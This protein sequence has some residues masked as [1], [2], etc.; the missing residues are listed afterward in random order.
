[1]IEPISQPAVSGL[2]GAVTNYLNAKALGVFL[3]VGSIWIIILL[4]LVTGYLLF[5]EMK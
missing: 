4:L 1:M 5:K 3:E 2:I